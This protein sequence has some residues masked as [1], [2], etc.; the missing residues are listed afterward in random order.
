MQT[1]VCTKCNTELPA[2]NKCF[3]KSQK[4]KYG[5]KS[6]C[7]A[8]ASED[9][10]MYRV[11]NHEI[12]IQKQRESAIRNKE[13]NYTSKQ[14]YY[15]NNKEK[16]MQ[17]AKIWCANNKEKK[18]SINKRY[19]KN[20]YEHVKIMHKQYRE[21][22]RE[23]KRMWWQKYY[24]RK[25]QLDINMTCEIWEDIKQYFNNQ[26]AYCGKD[27]KLEQEHFVCVSKSGEYTKNNIITACRNCN[28]SKSDSDFF[29]WYPKQAFY[30]KQREQKIL[31][32]LNY[33]PKTKVQQ[34]TLTI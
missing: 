27:K 19:V 5:L 24:N 3:S 11:N 23:Q 8:C 16:V 1:K 33:N 15:L 18:K 32:Y 13:A 28:A 4:G 17:R 21:N 31:K 25:K 9:Q 22:H 14:K 30:D 10:K 26:C 2:T 20:N 7:K 12:V 34:L 6:I 29:E